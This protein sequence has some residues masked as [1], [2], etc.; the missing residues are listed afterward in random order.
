MT[1]MAEET[2]S[3][4]GAECPYCGNVDHASDSDGMLY[5]ES[6]DEWECGLCG[7]PFLVSLH[8]SHSWTATPYD[9][10][11]DTLKQRDKSA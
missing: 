5:S 9:N 4:D 6:T 2:F 11:A 8:V 7:N 1:D 10:V 3:T